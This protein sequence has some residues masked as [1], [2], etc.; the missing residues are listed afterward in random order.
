MWRK[1]QNIV[2]AFIAAS[3]AVLVQFSLISAWPS[4][5]NSINL[6]LIILIFSRFFLGRY[7]A[8]FV[9]LFAG[10]WLD[11]LSF[12]L[13]GV[14]LVALFLSVLAADTVLRNWLTNR[15]LYSL[16]VLTVIVNLVYNFSFY[17]LLNVTR[18]EGRVFSLGQKSFWVSFGTELVWSLL[19]VLL[20]FNL[21]AALTKKM[22]PFFLE[23]K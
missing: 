1:Y 22:K 3:L 20:L 10:F 21:A 4:F 23:N 18:T 9:G 19:A 7:D 2:I 15:S 12:H 14:Y 5:F 17:L 16:L 8:V 13:F 11:F 6:I